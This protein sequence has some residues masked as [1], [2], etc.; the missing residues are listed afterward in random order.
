MTDYEFEKYLDKTLEEAG[1]G[2]R[3]ILSIADSTPPAA[4]FDRL[5]TI[6]KKVKE[7]GAVK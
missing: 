3:L 2:R 5:L 6:M 7:F 1:D 4:K